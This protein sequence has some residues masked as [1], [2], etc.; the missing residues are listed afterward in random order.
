MNVWIDGFACVNKI[1]LTQLTGYVAVCL[2]QT[3]QIK[4]LGKSL[5]QMQIRLQLQW[6]NRDRIMYAKEIEFW[7]GVVQEACRC[8]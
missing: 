2:L 7:G 3:D 8:H 4:A 6:E 1:C 5:L